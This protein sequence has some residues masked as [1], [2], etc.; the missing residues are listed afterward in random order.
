MLLGDWGA[1]SE[2]DRAVQEAIARKMIDL[3]RKRKKEGYNLLFIVTLGDNF[4]YGGLDDSCDFYI[5]RWFD[6][7][8][9]LA[10]DYQWLVVKGN[11]DWVCGI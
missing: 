7:Y 5:K 8:A 4:Y 3:H 9:E 1:H 2:T 6:I 11:H 10:T